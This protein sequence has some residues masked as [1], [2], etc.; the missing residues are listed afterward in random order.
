MAAAVCCLI[1]PALAPSARTSAPH[2]PLPDANHRA[3]CTSEP[4]GRSSATSC[5]GR[6]RRCP[7]EAEREAADAAMGGGGGRQSAVAD[8]GGLGGDET[9]LA[10]ASGGAPDEVGDVRDEE[11]HDEEEDLVVERTA[12]VLVCPGIAPLPLQLF[13]CIGVAV[14][15]RSHGYCRAFGRISFSSRLCL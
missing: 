4:P 14:G 10:A 1:L 9:A 8:E 12:I 3:G 6:L 2:C 5:S 13:T 11:R 15:R 7:E